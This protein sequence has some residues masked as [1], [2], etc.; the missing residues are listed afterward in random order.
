ML[1]SD[2]IDDYA[3]YFERLRQIFTAMDANYN[4]VAA[5]YDFTCHQCPDNCC[6]TRFYNH[7]YLEFFYLLAGIRELPED[8]RQE[9]GRKAREVCREIIADEARGRVPRHMCPLNVAGRC[10]LHGHR[11]MICRLHG[12]PHEIR[13]PDGRVAR[14]EG[15]AVFS[16]RF[17]DRDY[18]PFDRTPFYQEM[19]SLEKAF[20]KATGLDKKIKMTI[21]QMI[22]GG[23]DVL[24]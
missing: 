9:I 18:I 3:R 5:R 24:P 23:M 7:T 4:D 16:S 2:I 15:C 14:G 19:S 13:Y 12:I 6:R 20:R 1:P 8:R 11:L 10:G 17:Q 21:A 22:A